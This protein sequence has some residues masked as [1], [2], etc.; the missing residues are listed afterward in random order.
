MNM[1]TDDE[2]EVKVLQKMQADVR[3]VNEANGWFDDERSFGDD[4]ALAHSE[5]SE[6][7]DAYRDHG[8]ADTTLV[9]HAFVPDSQ[10]PEA[11]CDQIRVMPDNRRE[12]C[13]WGPN[14]MI[15]NTS[16]IPKPE[17]VGSEAADLLIR[18][19][20]TCERRGIDLAFEFRRKLR[21]NQTRSYRHG[22]RRL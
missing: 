1:D 2:R 22:G 9:R 3:A 7:L 11:T 21:Y 14:A 18:L 10:D 19:L 4:I 6:M 15:H 12:K 20:D 16:T 13:G 17:G 8:Y 5:L